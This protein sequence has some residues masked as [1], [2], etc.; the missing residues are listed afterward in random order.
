MD[1]AIRI[2]TVSSVDAVNG[3]ISVIYQDRGGEVTQAL[4]YLTFN[5]EYKMPDIGQKVL[6]AHLSNGAEMG[7]VLGTYWNKANS[8][9]APATYYKELGG[10]AFFK[11]D[12]KTG[13]LTINAEHITFNATGD[14]ARVTVKEIKQ[15]L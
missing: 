13:N 7:V 6:V 8:P 3:M 4:P 15:K 2:G 12:A 14:G 5:D 10:D 11:Y 9:G 1:D